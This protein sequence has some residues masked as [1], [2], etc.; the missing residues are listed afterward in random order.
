MALD[1]KI[2]NSVG[3][4]DGSGPEECKGQEIFQS[5]DKFPRDISK[6]RKRASRE[7]ISTTL[8]LPD[9][10]LVILHLKMSVY[11]MNKAAP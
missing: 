8:V 2:I 4:I 6:A 5:P 1:I 9:K 10:T 7:K 11:I 3:F